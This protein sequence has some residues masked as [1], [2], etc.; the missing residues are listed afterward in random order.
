MK[1]VTKVTLKGLSVL[2][3]LGYLTFYFIYE[4]TPVINN[5]VA[6]LINYFVKKDA[7]VSFK[8]LSGTLFSDAK[9][10][11]VVVELKNGEVIHV[12]KLDANFNL[13]SIIAGKYKFSRVRLDSVEVNVE[14]AKSSNKEEA[15]FSLYHEIGKADIIIDRL[16]ISDAR[17]IIDESKSKIYDQINYKGSFIYTDDQIDIHVKSLSANL[18]KESKKLHKFSTR[19]E[20][21]R[22][23]I[24]FNQM[25]INLENTEILGKGLLKFNVKNNYQIFLDDAKIVSE[26]LIFIDRFFNYEAVYQFQAELE[27]DRYKLS[28][29]VDVDSANVE[30][31]RFKKSVANVTYTYQMD[32]LNV[33]DSEIEVNGSRIRITGNIL[34]KNQYHASFENLDLAD[35]KLLDIKSRL[36]GEASF[37]QSKIDFSGTSNAINQIDLKNSSFDKFYLSSA[38]LQFENNDG[39][40][41]ISDNS[42]ISLPKS[43]RS[44]LNGE[45][46]VKKKTVYLNVLSNKTDYSNFL[47]SYSLPIIDGK[48]NG[49]HTLSG[50]FDQVNLESIL[51]SDS[52]F[53]N[54]YK[55]EV[56]KLNIKIN[57]IFGELEGNLDLKSEKTYLEGLE[58]DSLLTQFNF[59]GDS[60][61]L[62]NINFLK[63]Q[64]G[65]TANGYIYK[66]DSVSFYEFNEIKLSYNDYIISNSN[67]IRLKQ[68]DST[69][70]IDNFSFVAPGGGSIKSEG[71]YSS[72]EGKLNI[73]VN[74]IDMNPFNSLI[75]YE[76]SFL[77]IVNGTI[78]IMD[79]RDL[80]LKMNL[81]INKLSVYPKSDSTIFQ[82]IGKDTLNFGHVLTSLN[83]QNDELELNE[84]SINDKNERLYIKGNA[85]FFLNDTSSSNVIDNAKLDIKSEFNNID[86][87]QYNVFIG[88]YK[89][90]N[91]KFNGKIDIGG[92]VK[93]P[94]GRIDLRTENLKVNKLNFSGF[95]N[96]HF[97]QQFWLFDSIRIKVNESEVYGFGK[98]EISFE[99]NNFWEL[100]TSSPFEFNLKSK[101]DTI[102]ALNAISNEITAI[103]G[104]YEIDINIAGTFDHPYIQSGNL[105]FTDAYFLVD[106]IANPLLNINYYGEIYKK[107]LILKDFTAN[108]YYKKGGFLWFI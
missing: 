41:T 4:Y 1:R 55:T 91:G 17:Y 27:G 70:N 69:Y 65:L 3:L 8:N 63:G 23:G 47:K 61:R 58:F 56:A 94:S 77:G 37:D 60:I 101:G 104:D 74:N 93:N 5:S 103:I 79:F 6:D 40:F 13:L 7:T 48:I 90:L 75:D 29:S 102:T 105:R 54:K 85:K 84:L 12:K 64:N 89:E 76:H 68:I 35:L 57:D 25:N 88:Y 62:K 33:L 97:D 18:V 92:T 99:Y 72:S 83:Y 52:L 46:S 16:D 42:F 45:L 107:K 87:N 95:I 20:G 39:E 32:Q 11:N 73:S 86:L 66:K 2:F 82:R 71:F 81:D 28:A 30:H 10:E 59:V 78:D 22:T 80:K 100:F 50:S 36:N 96:S 44:S 14:N 19:I 24:I 98:K 43:S 106:R 51:F 15:F 53:F 49:S 34:N 67:N 21:D 108:T 26:D 38:S 9:M 31:L